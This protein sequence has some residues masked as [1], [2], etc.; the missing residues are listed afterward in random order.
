MNP[1]EQPIPLRTIVALPR[2][3]MLSGVALGV[4]SIS[5]GVGLMVYAIGW[6]EGRGAFGGALGGAAGCLAGGAGALFGTLTDWRRR[7]PATVYLQHVQHDAPAPMYRR[8]F[9]PASI[10]L[11]ALVVVAA[12][13]GLWLPLYVPMQTAG[14]LAFCAGSIEGARRN[15]A[16]RARAVFA[17]YADGLLDE[18]DTHA[19]DD[20]RA[21]DP[22]FDAEVRAY[23]QLSQEVDELMLR[24]LR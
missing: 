12:A 1:N 4:T 20:T 21:K 24:D 19:V 2:W 9:W 15:T 17:L 6:V 11:A 18:G 10:A 7:L 23:L 5:V 8:V 13:F 16:R 14:I 22:D 3:M